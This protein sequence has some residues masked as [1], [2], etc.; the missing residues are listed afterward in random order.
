[1]EEKGEENIVYLLFLQYVIL[2]VGAASRLGQGHLDMNLDTLCC[3]TCFDGLRFLS[4]KRSKR[5]CEEVL[6]TTCGM[7]NGRSHIAQKIHHNCI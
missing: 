4:L 3:E 6:S 2:K 5:S 1:M 7:Q